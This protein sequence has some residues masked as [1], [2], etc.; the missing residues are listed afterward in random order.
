MRS[1]LAKSVLVISI[2]LT[3]VSCAY[4][5]PPLTFDLKETRQPVGCTRILEETLESFPFNKLTLPE[6]AQWIRK[7]YEI[8]PNQTLATNGIYYLR[9]QQGSKDFTVDFPGE[10]AMSVAARQNENPPIVEE[11]LNCLGEPG[12]VQAHHDPTP[13]GPTYT[14][15][16]FWYP[17]RGLMFYSSI[18]A[19]AEAIDRR[20]PMPLVTYMKPGSLE[21]V[22]GSVYIVDPG[23]EQYQRIFSSVKPWPGSLEKIV[24][25]PPLERR[26]P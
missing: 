6:T 18:P 15:L 22:V 24:V 10:F 16:Q 26:E 25:D 9:W 14:V 23:S 2:T 12:F 1:Q 5:S 7:T 20:M 11:V 19:P 17:E 3:L 13:D 8:Q 4:P 21:E